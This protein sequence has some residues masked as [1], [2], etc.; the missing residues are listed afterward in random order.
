MKQKGEGKAMD[1]KWEMESERLC[2]RRITPQDFS[3]LC[4]MLQDPDVMYAWEHAF[5]DD[6]VRAWI[7]RRCEGYQAAGYDY[8]LAVEKATGAVVGQIG[9]LNETFCGRQCIGLGY[10]LKREFWHRGYATEGARAM[11]DY[12]F[13]VLGRGELVATIRPENL[14]SRKVAERLGMTEA[15]SFEKQYNGKTMTHLVYSM[16]T[17]AQKGGG[18]AR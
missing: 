9:L 12:A 10:I 7:R 3:V 14:S 18:T 8:F 11:A 5:S 16:R 6:E 13:G 17:D 1:G 4:E 15:G 2:F